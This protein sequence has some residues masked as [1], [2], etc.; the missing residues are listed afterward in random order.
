MA[1]HEVQVTLTGTFTIDD[2]RLSDYQATTV[3]DALKNQMSW[4]VDEG[5]I[6]QFVADTIENSKLTFKV[7]DYEA[8]SDL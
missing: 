3:E 8:S 7:G 5:E 4:L 2:N 6:V 1:T